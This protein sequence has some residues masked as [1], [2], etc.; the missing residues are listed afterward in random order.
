MEKR[1][2]IFELALSTGGGVPIVK[3]FTELAL[4]P[5]ERALLPSESVR[6]NDSVP[7]IY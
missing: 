2:F 7:N 4:L 3:E 1:E 5:S 6:L